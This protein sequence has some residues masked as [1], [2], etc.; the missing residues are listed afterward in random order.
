[1]SLK[2]NV[3][4][5]MLDKINMFSL[6]RLWTV[7]ASPSVLE[8]ILPAQTFL[9]L[10]AREKK[11]LNGARSDHFSLSHWGNGPLSE[12]SDLTLF[13]GSPA[14]RWHVTL[15]LHYTSS[16]VPGPLTCHPPTAARSSL[17]SVT[18]PPPDLL[19]R[20]FVFPSVVTEA[21]R[22]AW[23]P[24]FRHPSS[25]TARPSCLYPHCC[26]VC[27]AFSASHPL[28][29]LCSCCHHRP[30]WLYG[31]FTRYMGYCFMSFY[32]VSPC[33]L[34]RNMPYGAKGMFTLGRP[35]EYCK[36]CGSFEVLEQN[37]R[38]ENPVAAK[39]FLVCLEWQSRHFCRRQTAE[40]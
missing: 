24:H 20:H 2:Q 12:G 28:E 17:P 13:P 36:V 21:V 7:A 26:K 40:S 27:S 39:L 29:P 18:P 31:T 14:P 34:A 1:M 35:P 25:I 5:H 8:E 11:K 19:A 33:F 30:T 16:G 10:G 15:Y 23:G 22:R 4:F 38:S 37:T 32:E 9:T 3:L 6:W